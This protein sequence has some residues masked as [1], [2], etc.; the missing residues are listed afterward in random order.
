MTDAARVQPP[1]APVQLLA[2]IV[3]SAGDAIVGRGMD[4]TILAWNESAERLFGYRAAEMVG[5]NTDRMIPDEDRSDAAHLFGRA[6]AGHTVGLAHAVRIARDGRRVDVGLTISPI[7][8]AAGR[9]IGTSTI[10]RDI[11]EQLRVQEEIRLRERLAAVERLAAGLAGEFNNLVTAI[12]SYAELL[13][14]DLD[15]AHASH[16][17][18]LA[19]RQSAEGALRLTRRLEALARQR[20][21]E[22]ALVDLNALVVSALPRLRDIVGP[23]IGVER[24][25][26]RG[27]LPRVLTDRGQ[28]GEVLRIL[29]RFAR[30]RM[31]EGGLLSLVTERVGPPRGTDETSPGV[32]GQPAGDQDRARWV[33]LTYADTGPALDEAAGRSLF[34]PYV[35]A[36]GTAGIDLAAAHG[37]I[38][39]LGGKMTTIAP[40]REKTADE[41]RG[42]AIA[43]DMPAVGIE[44]EMISPPTDREPR[45]GTE[46]ILVVDDDQAVLSVMVKSL[47]RLG[48]NVQKASTGEEALAIA[49][50]YFAEPV[51]ML[52]ADVVLTGMT[53]PELADRLLVD[54]PRLEVLYVS[55]Y[56]QNTVAYHGRAGLEAAFLRK[57]FTPDALGRKVRDLLDARARRA[58]G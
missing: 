6:A 46:S 8:D 37:I 31:P 19:I 38:E 29:A 47:E 4:G 48:Y 39:R 33:R 43:V 27:P 54:R 14:L 28:L 58:A 21:M 24:R 13:L 7:N 25:P 15:E 34:E 42:L 16:A 30:S 26:N 44:D 17:D 3:A 41:S 35:P 1:E 5:S 32:A 20:P 57:P 10:Y 40:A 52:I 2:A 49:D 53:G 36:A 55:G 18:A 45:G 56:T 50:D 9:V 12:T 11:T 51:D 22:P 23:E